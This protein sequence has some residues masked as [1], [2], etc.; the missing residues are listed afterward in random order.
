MKKAI[1]Y[2]AAAVLL[3]AL[4]SSC[5]EIRDKEM[6]EQEKEKAVIL[7]AVTASFNS[8]YNPFIGTPYV[9]LLTNEALTKTAK[10]KY[11]GEFEIRNIVINSKFVMYHVIKPYTYTATGDVVKK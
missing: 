10:E 1:V 2:F 11:K 4:M 5:V 3:T 6:G 7:G 8:H 9:L